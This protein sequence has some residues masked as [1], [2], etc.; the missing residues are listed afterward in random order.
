MNDL[1]TCAHRGVL[2]SLF[3]N[4]YPSMIWLH[5]LISVVGS[6]LSLDYSS[7]S[8]LVHVLIKV[9]NTVCFK[10]LVT[11]VLGAFANQSVLDSAFS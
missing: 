10:L 3:S 2:A 7:I 6:V 5:L 4:F 11:N 9:S 1:V 8:L